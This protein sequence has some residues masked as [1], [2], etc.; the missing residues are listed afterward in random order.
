M[1]PLVV[2]LLTLGSYSN[3]TTAFA[4]MAVVAALTVLGMPLLAKSENRTKMPL[5]G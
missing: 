4:V 2:G 1:G 5:F 3:L